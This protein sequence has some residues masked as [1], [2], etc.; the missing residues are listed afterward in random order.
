M[1]NN[2]VT[3]Q[4]KKILVFGQ[5]GQLASALASLSHE[6]DEI[7]FLSRHD[8]DLVDTKAIRDF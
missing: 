1:F 4:L 2:I 6:D 7:T 3:T 5:S 8:C